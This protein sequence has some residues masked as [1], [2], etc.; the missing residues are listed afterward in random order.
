VKITQIPTGIPGW[1]DASYLTE[2][3]ITPGPGSYIRSRVVVSTK[4]ITQQLHDEEDRLRAKYPGCRYYVIPRVEAASASE[5]Q[6]SGS[7]DQEYLAQYVS[8]TIPA[9][10]KFTARRALQYMQSK[11]SGTSGRFGGKNVSFRLASGLNVLS[12]GSI[13]VKFANQGLVLLRGENKD[14]QN[15]SNGSGKTSCLSILPV[16][17]FGTTLKEQN[18]DAWASET[19]SE[20]AE[21]RV[22]LEVDQVGRVAVCRRR[23]PHAL[24]LHVNGSDKST[25]ITGKGKHQTQGKIEEAIG[26][27]LQ[28]LLN[29]VYITDSDFV[30]GGQK[31]RMDLINKFCNTERYEQ[32]LKSVTSDMAALNIQKKEMAVR[33]TFISESIE[34]TKSE[35]SS[36]KAVRHTTEWLGKYNSSLKKLKALKEKQAGL[37]SSE[38]FY[39]DMQKDIDDI[40]AEKQELE[41]QFK[42]AD[43]ACVV[44]QTAMHRAKKLI[45]K[46]DCPTCTQPATGVGKAIY[47]TSK[48]VAA[49]KSKLRARLAKGVATLQGKQVVVQGQ[50]AAYQQAVD[51]TNGSI[52][53]LRTILQEYRAAASE[54]EERN[55]QRNQRIIEL[56]N[57]LNKDIRVGQAVRQRLQDIDE[58]IEMMV[59]C[60]SAFHRSGIPLY[61]AAALC[62]VLNNAAQEYSE[63]FFLGQTGVRFSVFDGDMVVDIVNGAGSSTI[64]GQSTGEVAMAKVIASFALRAVAPRTNLL[65]LDEPSNG[66]DPAGAKM[67]A[68]GLVKLRGQFETIIITTHNSV[69]ENILA[70]EADQIWT[71]IKEKGISRLVI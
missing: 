3:S 28:M 11:I 15:R 60:Q 48:R 63:L 61:L 62:P 4:K 8:A 38:A 58:E 16:G 51:E 44:A 5:I 1:F 17:L 42:A 71:A 14:W 66:L 36:V 26:F 2:N 24:E 70:G 19:C 12:Y 31:S 34:T 46:G 64:K 55:E 54:E 68:Q 59:Y 41:N 18:N 69:M 33:Q 45:K 30:F 39:W 7:S 47:R 40:A 35:L 29:S 37:L 20:M 50:L 23:R 57:R 21:A 65:V 9:S 32:A 52:Q 43:M 49:Q 6:F 27:D 22:I 25:G 13:K 53:N 56:T 10:I 67:F